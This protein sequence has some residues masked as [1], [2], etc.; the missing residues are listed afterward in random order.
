MRAVNRTRPMFVGSL[1]N[2]AT[3]FV[4]IVPLMIAFGL[5]GYA[6]G[7]AVATVTQL[8][9]RAYYLR[10][11]FHGFKIMRHVLR[12]IAPSLPAAG[13]VLLLRLVAGGDR[14]LPRALAEVALYLAVTALATYYFERRLLIELL[15]YLRGRGGGIR[16]M[17]QALPQTGPQEP[18][19][20]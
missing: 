14:T 6:A 7:L 17:A 11:L 5:T 3:F 20:A 4:A 10:D 19:R 16:T 2:L 18:S 9:V 8:A 15:G 13:V 12:A 1:V